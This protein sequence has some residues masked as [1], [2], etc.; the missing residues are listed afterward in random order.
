MGCS[1]SSYK[2]H[3]NEHDDD[4]TV[5]SEAD[6]KSQT[7]IDSPYRLQAEDFTVNSYIAQG[8]MGVVYKGTRKSTKQ[9]VALKFFGYCKRAP[10]MDAIQAEI[11]IMM[12]LKGVHGVVQLYGTFLDTPNGIANIKDGKLWRN[13]YPVIVMQLL[14]HGTVLDRIHN[15]TTVSELD[16]KRMFKGF[17]NAL[18]SIHQ[19]KYI[20]C[21]LKLENI[22]FE[23]PT[24][25]T[26]IKIVDFGLMVKIANEGDIFIRK[27]ACGTRGYIAPE[28]LSH[29]EYSSSSDIW[30]AGCCL[31]SML[32]GLT[33]FHPENPEQSASGKYFPMVGKGWEGISDKAM[34]LVR[35]ILILNPDE[36]LTIEQIL[37]HPW[38]TTDVPDTNLGAEYFTRMKHLAL[39]Q[40]MRAFF[41][42]N[43]VGESSKIKREHLI[44]LL[45]VMRKAVK[46]STSSINASSNVIDSTDDPAESLTA[47][48]GGYPS[49]PVKA[50][51]DISAGTIEF[52]TRINAFKRM[53]VTSISTNSLI[54]DESGTSVEKE[55]TYEEFVD[56]IT[57]AGLPNLAQRS[58][59]NVFD[60]GNTGTISLKEFLITMLAF[61]PEEDHHPVD[62]A[63]IRMYFSVF[64]IND[65]GYVNLQDFNLAVGCMLESKRVNPTGFQPISM[66]NIE[67]LF[68]AIDTDQD[69]KIGFS[70]FKEF[71]NAIISMAS[72]SY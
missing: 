28:T 36:R 24:D 18:R 44:E 67:E 55:I 72:S 66:S 61:Q 65:T 50:S 21:D 33:P 48:P 8:G 62:E 14:D 10:N 63:V 42:Q 51:R 13:S 45:P 1:Q 4:K 43:S 41:L 58:V 31:Y 59:F 2:T 47:S 12:S 23:D 29:R 49:S 15:R 68:S 35:R 32:S 60:I 34:D 37:R 27:K 25:D 57:Q 16:L 11:D 46:S 39:R 20:H 53:V 7:E 70:E 30:Q 19:Q 64:D 71:Y 40:R 6:I 69:G 5:S 52:R 38:M 26:K 3:H 22:M 9:T 56:I 54:S 17:I